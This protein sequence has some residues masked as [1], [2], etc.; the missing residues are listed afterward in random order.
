MVAMSPAVQGADPRLF[1]SLLGGSHLHSGA[2]GVGGG[3][4]ISPSLELSLTALYTALYCFLFAF[5]YLQLWLI[6]HYGH[7]RFSFQS[8]FLFLCLLWAALRTTLF[9]FY[10]NNASQASR[11]QPLLYWLLY[12]CPVCLQ[13]FTL[14]LLNLYFTQVS[15]GRVRACVSV[16]L[17]TRYTVRERERRRGGGRE[18]ERDEGRCCL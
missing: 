8:V 3:G 6:L 12:C 10:F 9:S 4:A 15:R 2:E 18:R 11:L 7:K 17:S 13:F 5:V 1:T 16:C 14:C